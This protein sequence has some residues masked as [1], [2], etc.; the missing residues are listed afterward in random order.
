MPGVKGSLADLILLASFQPE[1]MHIGSLMEK[2]RTAFPDRAA[3]ISL[4]KFQKIWA[5]NNKRPALLAL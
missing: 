4:A 2:D 3:V 1:L 5:E